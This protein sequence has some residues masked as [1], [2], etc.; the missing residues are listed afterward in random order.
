MTEEVLV[1]IC[2]S[3]RTVRMTNWRSDGRWAFEA[4]LPVERGMANGR[5]EEVREWLSIHCERYIMDKVDRPK[6]VVKGLKVLPPC[7]ALW[8]YL[9]ILSYTWATKM[10]NLEKVNWYGLKLIFTLCFLT[11]WR[12]MPSHTFLHTYCCPS[13]SLSPSRRAWIPFQWL[14]EVQMRSS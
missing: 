10:A 1:V 9:A 8:R 3:A 7:P 12:F 6:S 13:L 4:D 11:A 5:S 2:W 14:E